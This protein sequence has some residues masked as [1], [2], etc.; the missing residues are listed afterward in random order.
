[1]K[2]FLLF[3]AI[4]AVL[5]CKN[6]DV[7]EAKAAVGK[8]LN[9]EGLMIFNVFRKVNR[10]L[11][12]Y[13]AEANHPDQITQHWKTKNGIRIEEWNEWTSDGVIDC[14]NFAM[15]AY[16]IL[17]KNG[18]AAKIVMQEDHMAV[19]ILYGGEWLIM[20]PEFSFLR[21][22]DGNGVIGLFKENGYIRPIVV[23]YEANGAVSWSYQQN[24]V[25]RELADQAI[26]PL[27]EAK[28]LEYW[29]SLN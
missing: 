21:E 10:T 23:I 9:S 11:P 7:E 2:I 25:K 13:G 14:D 8:E 18:A 4:A 6:F 26:A 12:P 27:Y 22:W 17:K 24:E 19:K 28:A 3:I 5:H 1:M 15:L 20:D 29:G 16:A